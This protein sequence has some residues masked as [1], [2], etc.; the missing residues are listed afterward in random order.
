MAGPLDD[1]VTRLNLQIEQFR[2]ET[3]TF[4]EVELREG[5]RAPLEAISAEPGYGFV[6]LRPRPEDTNGPEEWIVPVASIARIT[7]RPVEEEG[8]IGFAPPA[9][10]GG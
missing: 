2:G 6:T 3:E 10:G 9:K 4:V 5:S 7:L 8:Q 1:F